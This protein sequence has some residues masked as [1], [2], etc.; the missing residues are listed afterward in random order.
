MVKISQPLSQSCQL[1]GEISHE[2]IIK[3]WSSDRLAEVEGAT[4]VTKKG[5][6]G[7]KEKKRVVWSKIYVT[8]TPPEM[9][10]KGS[11]GPKIITQYVQASKSILPNNV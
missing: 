7:R 2:K 3:T 8:L 10:D 1:L 9:H 4:K 5:G 11:K 6:G